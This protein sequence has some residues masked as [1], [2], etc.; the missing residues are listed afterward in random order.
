[1]LITDFCRRVLLRVPNHRGASILP[2]RG[3]YANAAKAGP[4]FLTID[5]A[6]MVSLGSLRQFLK[7]IEKS[8]IVFTAKNH[9]P[10]LWKTP[11][12]GVE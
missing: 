9:R 5:K 2:F 4:I 3:G 1:L 8:E 7:T 6:Q 11:Y 12:E 10:I